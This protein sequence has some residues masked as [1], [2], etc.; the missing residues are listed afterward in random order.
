[1]ISRVASSLTDSSLILS[2]SPS[3]SLPFYPLP[4]SSLMEETIVTK[5]HQLTLTFTGTLTTTTPPLPTLPFDLIAEILCRLP[6]KIL[7]QLRCLCKS[8]NSLVSD[9]KF[10]KKH[11]CMSNTRHRL[12]LSSRNDLDE[13][14]L[15]DSP[16]PSDFP[17]FTVKQTQVSYPDCLKIEYD[18]P[19]YVCSCDGILCFTMYIG[20][21]VSPPILWNPSIRAFKILPPLD[22]KAFSIY[23]FGYDHYIDKYKIVAVSLVVDENQ[24]IVE[25]CLQ[26][27]NILL[28]TKLK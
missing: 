15:F 9:P 16:M 4:F 11:L 18:S 20:Y 8:V 7:I 14:V 17:T 21:D 3:L 25:D 12:M 5:T 27:K 13:L 28:R 10:A 6:V 2:L 19:L 1:M 24:Y 22:N 23:S 26:K